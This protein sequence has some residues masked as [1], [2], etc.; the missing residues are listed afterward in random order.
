MFLWKDR[1]NGKRK[2]Q[3]KMR[4]CSLFPPIF[5]ISFFVLCVQYCMSPFTPISPR[6]PPFILRL[7]PFSLIPPPPLFPPVSPVFT[8]FSGEWVIVVVP[9]RGAHRALCL[10]CAYAVRK[11]GCFPSPVATGPRVLTSAPYSPCWYTR[12]FFY[13]CDACHGSQGPEFCTPCCFELMVHASVGRRFS[14]VFSG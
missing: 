13:Q 8:G 6:F 1:E 4:V 10:R 2:N 3:G 5:P 7:P 11:A 9:E 12:D 14:G